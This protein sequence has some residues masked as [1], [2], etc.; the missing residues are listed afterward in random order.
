M[1]DETSRRDSSLPRRVRSRRWLATGPVI[2]RL[3]IPV[4]GVALALPVVVAIEEKVDSLSW[5]VAACL[6]AA[7]MRVS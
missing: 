3:I 2:A 5:V 6:Y 1:V 7:D 4:L